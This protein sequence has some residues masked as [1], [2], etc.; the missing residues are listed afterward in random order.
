MVSSGRLRL[1][2]VV[3]GRQQP[4]EQRR[5]FHYVRTGTCYREAVQ[6][7]DTRKPTRASVLTGDNVLIGG[8]IFGADDNGNSSMNVVVRGLGPSLAAAG[9]HGSLD[10]PALQLYDS[11][12]SLTAVNDDWM[13]DSDA[14][15]LQNLGLAPADSREAA[16]KRFLGSGFQNGTFTAVV[17]GKNRGT[18]VGLVE[19]Y[20]LDRFSGVRLANISTRAYVGLNDQV[21]I[22]GFILAG[23][24]GT[25]VIVLRG[26]GPSTGIASALG[27]PTLTLYDGQGTVVAQNDNW[28]DSQEADIRRT[29]LAPQRETES[30]MLV[31][32]SSGNYTAVVRGK[33]QGTG[34]G[35][36]EVYSLQ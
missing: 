1:R 22:A 14:A 17:S 26:L 3:L 28:R 8:F 4:A 5:V 6:H 29:T 16:L 35:L 19:V 27:D 7:L 25:G 23:G 30:A 10:D 9:V 31:T 2:Y 36:V 34:I 32:L 11:T 33:D 18:G 13:T 20:D 15:D 24:N 21:L 12:G